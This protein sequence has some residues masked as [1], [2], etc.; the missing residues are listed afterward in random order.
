MRRLLNRTA[1]LLE[2]QPH[3][4]QAPGLRVILEA[5][6]TDEHRY[7]SALAA[8][9]RT[10]KASDVSSWARSAGLG[11]ALVALRSAAES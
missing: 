11:A 8:L 7:S 1:D 9:K 6:T 2:R 10:T 4:L 3:M 5:L